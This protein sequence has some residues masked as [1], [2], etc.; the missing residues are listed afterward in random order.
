VVGPGSVMLVVVGS[1]VLVVVGSMVV[2]GGVVVVVVG[3]VV[4]GSVVVG[5][6]VVGSVVVGFVVVV[7]VVLDVGPVVLDVVVPGSVE[8]DDGVVVDSVEVGVPVGGV[9]PSDVAGGCPTVAGELV[10]PVTVTSLDAEVDPEVDRANDGCPL[11]VPAVPGSD[12][13][14]GTP[15]VPG[16]AAVSERGRPAVD[17]PAEAPPCAGALLGTSRRRLCEVRTVRVVGGVGDDRLGRR[18]AARAEDGRGCG[19]VLD[20]ACGGATCTYLWIR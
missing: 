13:G 1:V 17:A 18:A 12:L 20:P 5:W 10:A 15:V 2:V 4:V 7:P 19:P 9:V 14:R 8:A 16:G 6:V 3:R 11:P